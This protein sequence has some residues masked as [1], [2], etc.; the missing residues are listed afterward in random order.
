MRKIGVICLSL[1][2]ALGLLGVGYA[3]WTDEIFIDG[4]VETGTLCVEFGNTEI[5]DPHQPVNFGGDYP[6]D[7]PDYTCNPGFTQGPDGLRF[8]QLD[9][10]VGWGTVER[11]PDPETGKYKTLRVTLNNTYPCYFNEVTFY[12]E[13]CGTIPWRINGAIVMWDNDGTKLFATIVSPGTYIAMDFNGD[14]APDLEMMWG[15]SIGAQVEPGGLP[16]EV[17]FWLHVLQPAPQ[18][19]TLEFTIELMVVQWD[20]YPYRR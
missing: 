7:L 1:L 6:T 14:G 19:D 17:S 12:P 10:N 8:W 20:E 4:T 9:K 3:A 13:N 11:V 18:N 2:L 15:N 16:P 5:R